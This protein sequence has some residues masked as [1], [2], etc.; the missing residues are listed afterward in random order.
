MP[1][2]EMS[3]NSNNN[4]IATSQHLSQFDFKDLVKYPDF[5]NFLSQI[6]PLESI[7]QIHNL[8][9]V[10]Y[11]NL[12]YPLF[13]LSFGNPDKSSPTFALFSGVHGLERIGVQA[14]NALLGTFISRLEWDSLTQ[15]IFSKLRF[16]VFPFINPIGLVNG[17]RSNGQ[18]VDLMRNSP[19]QVQDRL[20]PLYGGQK[21]SAMLP[22][23]QG[24]PQM[25]ETETQAVYTLFEQELC[26]SSLLV[27][28][29][30]HS[31]FGLQDRIWFPYAC[32]RAPYECFSETTRFFEVFDKSYPHHFYQ[33]EPTSH[34]YQI[35]GD[36]WDYLFKKYKAQNPEGTYLPLT[37][38]MG[39]WSWIKKNP[40]QIFSKWGLFH[41]LKNHRQ[42]RVLRRHLT[43]FDYV[44]RAL[45]TPNQWAKMSNNQKEHYW[46]LG[47]KRWYE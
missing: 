43:F 44:M 23:Y 40:L 21:I 6:E 28:L 12:H 22:W 4:Q 3:S 46:Q 30:F 9:E 39:S 19:T 32:Q 42:K 31:G 2:Q 13:A 15:E 45:L 7:I 20:Y 35:A 14:L 24:L 47:L 1:T 10:Q 34:Q 33:I 16:V 29:D 26:A 27:T 36:L 41:P 25:P 5:R 18:G 37:L 8:G 38:E 17:Y 11:K